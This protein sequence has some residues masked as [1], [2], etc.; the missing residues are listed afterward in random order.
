MKSTKARSAFLRCDWI[1]AAEW[2][3]IPGSG[4]FFVIITDW[5]LNFIGRRKKKN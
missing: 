3:T 1:Y 2:T 4:L 5:H